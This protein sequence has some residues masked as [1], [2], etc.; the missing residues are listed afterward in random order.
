MMD[1]YQS[2]EPETHDTP[3]PP[4]SSNPSVGTD[5]NFLVTPSKN[6]PIAVDALF[7]NKNEYPFLEVN[8]INDQGQFILSPK[9]DSTKNLLFSLPYYQLG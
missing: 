4:S 3:H 6:Y 1:D 7:A 9:N 8:T 5:R 2:N